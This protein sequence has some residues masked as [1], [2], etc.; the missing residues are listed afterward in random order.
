MIPVVASHGAWHGLEVEGAEGLQTDG[1]GD[2][3]VETRLLD[4]RTLLVLQVRCLQ[5]QREL[6]NEHDRVNSCVAE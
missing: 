6:K 2:A 3:L 4:V 5:P 1:L